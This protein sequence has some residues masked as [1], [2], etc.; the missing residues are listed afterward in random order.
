VTPGPR[1]TCLGCRGV[2]DQRELIRLTRRPEGAVVVDARGRA[3]GRGAYVCG[4]GCV[5]RLMKGGRLSHAFRRP[6]RAE[7]GLVSAVRERV[8][9]MR[10]ESNATSS[11]R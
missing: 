6:S 3:G 11:R 5:E 7:P 10:I 4:D 9:G 8:E 2:R 1:R